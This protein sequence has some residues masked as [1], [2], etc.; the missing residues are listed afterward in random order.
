MCVNTETNRYRK[1]E[2]ALDLTLALGNANTLLAATTRWCCRAFHRHN[3][4]YA[5]VLYSS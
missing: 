4:T 2:A 1:T 3:G 5:D